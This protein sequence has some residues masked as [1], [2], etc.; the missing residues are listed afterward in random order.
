MRSADAHADLVASLQ[1]EWLADDLEPPQA[2][3]GWDESRLR[4]WFENGGEEIGEEPAATAMAPPKPA[5]APPKPAMAPPAMT[6]DVVLIPRMCDAFGPLRSHPDVQSIYGS[7]E[8]LEPLHGTLATCTEGT[9]PVGVVFCCPHPRFLGK[10]LQTMDSPLP[11]AIASAC[12]AAGIPI[13][14]Y[15]HPGVDGSGGSDEYTR[16]GSAGSTQMAPFVPSMSTDSVQAIAYMAQHGNCE[17][18]FCVGASMGWHGSVSHLELAHRPD[19]PKA[20]DGFVSLAASP[21]MP[22]FLAAMMPT[23]QAE[24]FTKRFYHTHTL[25]HDAPKL[26]INGGKDELCPKDLLDKLLGHVKDPI[27]EMLPDADHL[28]TGL[29]QQIAKRVV[30]FIQSG[31]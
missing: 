26:F 16:H 27:V 15:N 10:S 25:M 18:I 3:I 13:L 2:S 28:F 4:A 30:D 31:K 23:D 12:V 17:K 29:E 11:T 5:M 19:G 20:A 9:S 7:N 8:Q 6:R 22:R 24:I 14:R 1:D 21:K